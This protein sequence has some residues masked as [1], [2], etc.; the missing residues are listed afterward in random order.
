M[1]VIRFLLPF[2]CGFKFLKGAE[3][4][5]LRLTK[6]GTVDVKTVMDAQMPQTVYDINGMRM[7]KTDNLPEGIFI[8]NGKKIYRQKQ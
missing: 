2:R 1:T 6:D 4:R 8:I 3:T 7:N 5:G